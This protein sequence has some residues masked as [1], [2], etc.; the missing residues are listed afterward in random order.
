MA[1]NVW[2][3]VLSRIE[4]KVNRHSFYTWFKPTRLVDETCQKLSVQVLNGLFRDWLTQ[5]GLASLPRLSPSLGGKVSRLDRH[6]RSGEEVYRQP[7]PPKN[8]RP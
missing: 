8:H 4:V 6:D 5:L 2:D 1:L 3:D 7:L